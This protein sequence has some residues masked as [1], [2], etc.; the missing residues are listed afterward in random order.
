M[1]CS[2]AHP[3]LDVPAS[4]F[5]VPPSETDFR[6][7]LS[8]DRPVPLSCTRPCYGTISNHDF[9]TP[10]WTVTHLHRLAWDFPRREPATPAYK[11]RFCKCSRQRRLASDGSSRLSRQQNHQPCTLHGTSVVDF[12][13][14]PSN[15]V[16]YNHNRRQWGACALGSIFTVEPY[17]SRLAW[18]CLGSTPLVRGCTCASNSHGTVDCKFV[19]QVYEV[20]AGYTVHQTDVT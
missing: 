6:L 13:S 1:Q 8:T 14:E 9:Q 15:Q 12:V 20:H 5:T 7:A 2:I 11:D 3:N 18:Y 10:A 4:V 19:P 17:G 16:G